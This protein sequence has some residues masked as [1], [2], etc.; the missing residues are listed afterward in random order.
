MDSVKALRNELEQ[1]KGWR[2]RIQKDRKQATKD[3]K[4][5]KRQYLHYEKAL[6]VVKEVGLK[7]QQELEYHISNLV[8]AAITSVFPN[9]SCQFKVQF[10]QRRGKTE[11]DLM[12]EKNGEYIHPYDDAGG[13]VDIVSF[14]LRVA[15]LSMTRN[16]TRPLLLLDEPFKHLSTD[17]Q[18][19]ASMMLK[20]LADNI[21]IQIIYIS[22]AGIAAS[23]YADK[24]FHVTTENEISKI[25]E[26]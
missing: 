17:L 14:A 12:L 26:V 19:R 9:N 8:S 18:E 23:E 1:Q 11:C 5:T 16:K 25:K 4:Y 20:E 15:A 6:E 7:T 24:Q 2:D 22:H 13:V 10:V 3:R 21:G